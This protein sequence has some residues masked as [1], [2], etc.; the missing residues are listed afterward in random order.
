LNLALAKSSDVTH[1]D[2]AQLR[3]GDQIRMPAAYANAEVFAHV[4][5]RLEQIVR[6]YDP[7]APD[8][9]RTDIIQVLGEELGVWP[10]ECLAAEESL[11]PRL[12]A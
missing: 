2:I 1:K 3:A 12:V 5:D 7:A 11:R 9:V 4:V 8:M 6:A 10:E